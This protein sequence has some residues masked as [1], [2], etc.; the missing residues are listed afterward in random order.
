MHRGDKRNDIFAGTGVMGPLLK[1]VRY[2]LSQHYEKLTH[3]LLCRINIVISFYLKGPPKRFILR[4]RPKIYS[5]DSGA[6][7]DEKKNHPG[8]RKF[9]YFEEIN[10]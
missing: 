4:F 2:S 10:M 1:W 3:D 7:G 5:F 9:I 6:L 8:G